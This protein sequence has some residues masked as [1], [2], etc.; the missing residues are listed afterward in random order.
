M[1]LGFIHVH[2]TFSISRIRSLPSHSSNSTSL[3]ALE[4]FFP[5]FFSS[6][7]TWLYP[8]ANV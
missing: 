7:I 1:S 4:F 8:K 3:Y 5:F 2:K 6:E